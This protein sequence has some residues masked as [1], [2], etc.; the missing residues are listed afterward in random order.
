[1]AA[2]AALV[3]FGVLAAYVLAKRSEGKKPD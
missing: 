2:A 1:L 3:I